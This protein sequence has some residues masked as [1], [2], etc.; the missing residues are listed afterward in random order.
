MALQRVTPQYQE[1]LPVVRPIV[2]RLG[3]KPAGSGAVAAHQCG[4]RLRGSHPLRTRW[5]PANV[6]SLGPSAVALIAAYEDVY[7]VTI[8]Q[9]GETRVGAVRHWLW[10]FATPET[11]VYRICH[12]RG[13]DEAA[14]VLGADF[15][16]VLVR[17]G[18]A[19]YRRFTSALH[20]G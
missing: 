12:G 4:R 16:G 7:A 6:G 10:A 19:P 14:E 2:W 18:W 8:M 13:F 11:T 5:G 17:D 9:P 15:D 3:Q 20:R 1:D